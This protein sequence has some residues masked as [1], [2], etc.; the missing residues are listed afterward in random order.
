M[1]WQKKTVELVELQE[2]DGNRWR[3]NL[4][5]IQ[6]TAV[7]A[8]SVSIQRVTQLAAGRMAWRVGCHLLELPGYL[9]MEPLSS[10]PGSIDLVHIALLLLLLLLV[11]NALLLLVVV[12][13]LLLVLLHVIIIIA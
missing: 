4:Q 11:H 7:T 13:V 3:G 8:C 9:L 6:E 10:L 2:V 5:S 12:V 1:C